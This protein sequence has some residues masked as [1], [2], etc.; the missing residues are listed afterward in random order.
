MIEIDSV[1]KRS[2]QRHYDLATLFYRLLWG[3][4]IHHGLW[5]AD[6]T[7]EQAQRQ[8]TET[9]A[10]RAGLHLRPQD[11]LDVGCGMGGS[12]IWLARNYHSRVTGITLSRVQQWWARFAGVSAG[13]GGRT[14]F[15]RQD[16]ELANFSPKSF[17]VVWSI[18]CTEHLFDKAA[19]FQRAFDWLRPGGRVA[20]CAWLSTDD[21]DEKQRRQLE[22]VCRGM[23]CPSLGSESDYR[24]WM[25]SAGL[26]VCA[27]EDWSAR[28]A[29]TWRICQD[30]IR[31][32][33]MHGLAKRIDREQVDFLDHFQTMIDAYESNALRYGCLIAERP[34]VAC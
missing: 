31:R 34:A 2:I 17:D 32:W 3:P 7:P 29:R 33:N 5:N 10:H 23:L 11:V 28:V 15:L 30:R 19:F 12:S 25:E 26:R 24:R 4:H 13:V 9:L 21:A 20:I 1:Q 27:S 22:A 6:E 14:R 18:E 16:V 8:L